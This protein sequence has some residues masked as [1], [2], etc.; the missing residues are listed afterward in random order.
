MKH[1]LYKKKKKKKT[2]A[3]PNIIKLHDLQI[4]NIN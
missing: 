2:E 3:K 1:I 4:G